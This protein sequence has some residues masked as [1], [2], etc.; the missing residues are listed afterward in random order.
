MAPVSDVGLKSKIPHNTRRLLGPTA[1]ETGAFP[2]IP[3][4]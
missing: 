3:S 1:K 2:L 4:K